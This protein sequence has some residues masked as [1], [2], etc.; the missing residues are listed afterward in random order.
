MFLHIV[1][2]DSPHFFCY[3][4]RMKR[5]LLF[6]V[7]A[8]V[9]VCGTG[10]A[11]TKAVKRTTDVLCLVPSGVGLVKAIC[12][13]DRKGIW[14][15]GLSTA[16]T[17]AV[18]YGL[19]A[20]VRKD[21]PDGDGHHA[22]PSTHTAV[23]W[24]GAT[25]LMRRHGWKWGVPAY[26]VATYVAWGRVYTKR[27]D[28]WDVLAGAAI[29]A[30]AALIYTRRSDRGTEIALSPATWGRESCGLACRITF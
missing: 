29:G 10:R 16:T 13:H 17:L 21:R 4:C 9:L 11:Q 28:A 2:P 23:V 12:D 27:H 1:I 26:A 5:I 8:F 19:E 25:Y 20:I 30:G 22:F 24:D 6:H 18:N 7:L 14:Q 15:L 3:F